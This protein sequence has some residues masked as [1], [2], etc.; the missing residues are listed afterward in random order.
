MAVELVNFKFVGVYITEDLSW[1]LHIPYLIKKAHWCLQLLSLQP[2]ILTTF[3]CCTVE[4]ILTNC[5]T[6][7]YGNITAFD[8]KA[9]QQVVKTVKTP[10]TRVTTCLSLW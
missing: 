2:R 1:N 3:Y 7:W 5:I 10:H 4:S 9:Q 8:H 6:V